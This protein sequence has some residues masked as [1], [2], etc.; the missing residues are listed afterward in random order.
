MMKMEMSQK[1]AVG[2]YEGEA[3]GEEMKY[4]MEESVKKSKSAK[5]HHIW[6]N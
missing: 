4:Q 5:G 3:R 2:K 6:G 1:K